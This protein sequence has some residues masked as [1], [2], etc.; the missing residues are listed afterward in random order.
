VL[1]DEVASMAVRENPAEVIRHIALCGR[2][3]APQNL[4]E[5]RRLEIANTVGRGQAAVKAGQRFQPAWATGLNLAQTA[6]VSA[7]TD[8]VARSH[9]RKS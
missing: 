2:R 4:A 1:A 3:F 8:R 5:V 9:H 6:R 7:D